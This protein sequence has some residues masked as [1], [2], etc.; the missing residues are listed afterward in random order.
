[1]FQIESASYGRVAVILR[2]RV[3]GVATMETSQNTSTESEGHSPFAG[4]NQR[5]VLEAY[6]QQDELM[7]KISEQKM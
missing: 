4:K 5:F 1:M 7:M 6:R 2:V 3:A